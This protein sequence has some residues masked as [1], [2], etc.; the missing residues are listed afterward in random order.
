MDAAQENANPIVDHMLTSADFALKFDTKGMKQHET[1]VL[2]FTREQLGNGLGVNADSSLFN[3][4]RVDLHG[5]SAPLGHSF[6]FVLGH[7]DNMQ[8]PDGILTGAKA[9][10]TDQTTGAAHLF[11]ALTVPGKNKMESIHVHQTEAAKQQGAQTALRRAARWRENASGDKLLSPESVVHGVTESSVDLGN[12][13]KSVKYLVTPYS[14]DGEMKPSAMHRLLT[15]NGNNKQF[16]G[17]RYHPANRKTV[18]HLGQEAIVMTDADFNAI[19]APLTDSLELTSKHPFEN[20]LYV[21][22]TKLDDLEAPDHVTLGGTFVREPLATTES[23]FARLNDLVRDDTQSQ[24]AVQANT[25]TA[26]ILKAIHPECKGVTAEQATMTA[27]DSAMSD[28]D[29]TSEEV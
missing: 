12:G 3:L 28:L 6:G 29:V 7:S 13:K 4:Q 5:T 18:P 2:G 24:S 16:F 9:V 15:Q 14:T 10:F 17:G 1:R 8:N 11:H 23:S 25:S 20:G 26:D 22:M 21:H 19:K 27:L